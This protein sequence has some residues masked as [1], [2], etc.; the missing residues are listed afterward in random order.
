MD[1]NVAD[2]LDNT[3]ESQ[4]DTKILHT[5]S[6]QRSAME[7]RTLAIQRLSFEG[8]SGEDRNQTVSDYISAENKLAQLNNNHNMCAPLPLSLLLRYIPSVPRHG[9]VL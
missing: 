4:A 5:E 9:D 2:M 8:I 7:Q 6:L 1:K 3:S